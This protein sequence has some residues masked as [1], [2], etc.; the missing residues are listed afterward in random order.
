MTNY[1]DIEN[2]SKRI[3]GYAV[4]TPLLESPLLNKKLNGRVLFKAEP[5]QITGSF[6][7][8]GAFNKLSILNQKKKLKGVVAYSSVN[9]AQGVAAASTHFTVPA[10]I[11][12]PL[13]A[14]SIKLTNTR[15][16]N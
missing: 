12:M 16:G 3:S 6:K 1:K 15:Q 13:D 11:V 7:F 5:L 2:A 9:H 4:I 14:P 8:R 10:I